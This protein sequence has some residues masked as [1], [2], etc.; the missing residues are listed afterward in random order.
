MEESHDPTMS[1]RC[2]A[3]FFAKTK[4]AIEIRPGMDTPCL[5]WQAAHLTWGY[6]Q[7]G[8][9]G[10]PELAHR[11]A[12][13]FANGPIPQGLCVLHKCD[14]PPCVAV[15][16]LFLGTN[17][18]NT[19]DMMAK[20]RQ[21]LVRARGDANGSRLHPE[22]RQRGDAHWSRL[23]P[24]RLARGDAH[25]ARLHPERLAG[26]ANGN[27]K[28]NDDKIRSIFQLHAQGW[29]NTRIA[30]QF[31]VHRKHIGRILSRK[32]WAHVELESIS[33]HDPDPQV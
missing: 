17:K 19:H 23:Q 32:K 13:I 11:V 8:I 6:G 30:A 33:G 25:W 22:S 21:S 28:L 31:G 5:E 4:L 12:W 20:G 9:A 26:S 1:A 10:K 16:H 15:E 27:A 2:R 24:E 18:D 3:R 7:F 29:T 14:N